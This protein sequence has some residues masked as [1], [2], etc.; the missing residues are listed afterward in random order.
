MN[1]CTLVALKQLPAAQFGSAIGPEHVDG[2][3]QLGTILPGIELATV[4]GSDFR[5]RLARG[6][7]WCALPW[8]HLPAHAE[9]HTTPR[10]TPPHQMS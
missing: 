2:E 4:R 9:V 8:Q 7:V 6:A 3:M 5:S 1:P 10:P